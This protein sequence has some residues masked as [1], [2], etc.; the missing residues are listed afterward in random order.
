M[1]KP[2]VLLIPCAF[3]VLD[4]SWLFQEKKNQSIV[5]TKAPTMTPLKMMQVRCKLMEYIVMHQ[6]GLRIEVVVRAMRQA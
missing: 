1:G 3:L 2:I 5:R 6:S 4:G